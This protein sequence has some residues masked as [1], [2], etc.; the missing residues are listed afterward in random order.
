MAVELGKTP[1]NI[2]ALI[3]LV[4]LAPQG[5]LLIEM[6]LSYTCVGMRL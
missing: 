6:P 1:M 5:Y 4:E 3:S 2:D